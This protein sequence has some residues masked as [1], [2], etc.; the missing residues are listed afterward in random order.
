LF[1]KDVKP[2]FISTT[3]IPFSGFCLTSLHVTTITVKFLLCYPIIVFIW[4]LLL[5]LLLLLGGSNHGMNLVGTR[6]ETMRQR[7]RSGELSLMCNSQLDISSIYYPPSQ[8]E[9]LVG[10]SSLPRSSS[11]SSLMIDPNKVKGCST[12]GCNISKHIV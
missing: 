12:F 10:A 9:A 2:D 3:K 5:F 11:D 4:F 6:L 7:S 1:T 8:P